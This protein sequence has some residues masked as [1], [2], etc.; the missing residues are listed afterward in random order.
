[1]LLLK[2]RKKQDT[3]IQIL[4]EREKERERLRPKNAKLKSMGDLYDKE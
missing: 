3:H 4:N 2:R 1:M